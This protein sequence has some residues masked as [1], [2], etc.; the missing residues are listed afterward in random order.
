MLPA[1]H[2]AYVPE[3]DPQSRL[4]E[5]GSGFEHLP[6]FELESVAGTELPAQDLGALKRKA[7]SP[8]SPAEEQPSVSGVRTSEGA[9]VVNEETEAKL[10]ILRERMER[11]RRDKERLQ[12]IQ[13]LEELEE[14]TK[15]EILEQ[16]KKAMGYRACCLF[17][18]MP[19]LFRS[20]H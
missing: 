6:P 7:V 13:E 19:N 5:L 1:Q 14:R 3:L 20:C 11:I 16:Q 12:Q 17:L 4:S 10:A 9:N 8:A 18:M 15:R 2:Q